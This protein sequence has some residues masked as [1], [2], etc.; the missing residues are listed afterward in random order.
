MVILF[1]IGNTQIVLGV[2]KDGARFHKWR[3]STQRSVTE[4]EIFAVASVLFERQLGKIPDVEG[5]V[6]AWSYRL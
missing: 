2:T 6:I 3:F 4:D 5:A 1:D